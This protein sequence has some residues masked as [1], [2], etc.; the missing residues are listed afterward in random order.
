[1]FCICYYK[2]SFNSLRVHNFK[3]N[4]LSFFLNYILRSPHQTQMGKRNDNRQP[5]L[6]LPSKYKYSRYINHWGTTGTV[7]FYCEVKKSYLSFSIIHI[8]YFTNRRDKIKILSKFNSWVEL[9]CLCWE[10]G[11]KPP[12]PSCPLTLLVH[13]VLIKKKFSRTN[14][15]L[16][17][18]WVTKTK[19]T[20][21][22]Y[23]I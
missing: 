16:H 15:N 21:F 5:V 8:Q 3:K 13:I 14:K 9:S 12:P 10:L 11:M 1:M 23:I 22:I 7:N 2:V 6:G 19:L 18:R 20:F 4:I 17:G